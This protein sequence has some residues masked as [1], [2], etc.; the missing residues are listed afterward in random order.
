[1]TSKIKHVTLGFELSAEK[2]IISS[3]HSSLAPE[4]ISGKR[5][6]LTVG[7]KNNGG[8]LLLKFSGSDLVSVRAGMNT[9]LRLTLSALKSIRTAN[10][11]EQ[12]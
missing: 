4:A 11:L 7:E 12:K 8:T 1:L 10:E 3:L 9:I 6:S 2:R 5:L